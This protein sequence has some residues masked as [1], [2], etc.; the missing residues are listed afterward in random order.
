A[1]EH[2]H[3]LQI[4][5]RSLV[6]A[7]D[8]CA[9]LFSHRG[10]AKYRRVPRRV[11]ALRQFRITDLQWQA[12][13]LPIALAF[14]LES[15]HAGRMG[16]VSPSPSGATESQLPLDSWEELVQDNASLRDLEPDV[17]ALLVNR[18]GSARDYFRLGIDHCYR[19]A[20]LL[21]LHWRGFTGGDEVWREI[22]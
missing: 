7:C 16:A 22:E 11:E 6:C 21:R 12:L 19:L 17:E 9:I 14:F 8:P 3:L 2:E 4:G 13:G 15:S 18:V 20:G 5:R 10:G 1:D